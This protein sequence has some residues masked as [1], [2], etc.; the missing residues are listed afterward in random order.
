M[1]KMMKMTEEICPH[2]NV[3]VCIQ[4]EGVT[5]YKCFD[6]NKFIID[7]PIRTWRNKGDKWM[8]ND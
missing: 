7:P 3:E 1:K 6:C 5:Y 4:T 8:E 2:E